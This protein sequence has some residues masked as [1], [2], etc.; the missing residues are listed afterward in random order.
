MFKRLFMVVLA[1][2]FSVTVLSEVVKADAYEYENINELAD[3]VASVINKKNAYTFKY[4]IDKSDYIVDLNA[5]V[6]WKNK[7]VTFNGFIFRSETVFKKEKFYAV[8]NLKNN[9]VK[10]DSKSYKKDRDAFNYIIGVWNLEKNS[11]YAKSLGHYLLGVFSVIGEDTTVNESGNGAVLNRV[12]EANDTTY[13]SEIMF[14][15]SKVLKMKGYSE[16]NVIKIEMK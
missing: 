13:Y 3:S 7:T 15:K 16:G 6:N 14:N 5:T 10:T 9:K 1:I 11:E 12:W 4:K 2:V 8:L